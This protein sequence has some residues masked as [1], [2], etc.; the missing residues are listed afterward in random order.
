M[1]LSLLDKIFLT[2]YDSLVQ[3]QDHTCKRL[4]MANSFTNLDIGWFLKI[5]FYINVEIKELA[6][7]KECGESL[8]FCNSLMKSL[9]PPLFLS[10]EKSYIPGISIPPSSSFFHVTD[11]EIITVSHVR[12]VRLGE[13]WFFLVI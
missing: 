10:Q 9:S 5:I 3:Q 7:K 11:Q 6:D 12:N 2:C 13:C 4:L 1:I 8:L